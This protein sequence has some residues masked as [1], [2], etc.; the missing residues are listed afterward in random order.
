MAKPYRMLHDAIGVAVQTGVPLAVRR[1]CTPHEVATWVAIRFLM[2]TTNRTA[3]GL[4]EIAEEMNTK[5]YPRVRIWVDRLVAATML[6]IIG[7][8]PL[9][10]LADPR[11]IYR[12]PWRTIIEQS[13]IEAE[14]C[15][16]GTTK[17]R[18]AQIALGRDIQQ[19]ALD[20][21]VIDRSQ[22][23]V[24]DRS[25]APVIDRSQEP[26]FPV[27]DRS[28]EMAF[29]VIDRSQ[30]GRKEGRKEGRKIARARESSLSS[31]DFV[32]EPSFASIPTPANEWA[33]PSHPVALWNEFAE[34]QRPGDAMLLSALAAE[35]DAPTGGFG[36]YWL[37]R[38]IL[39]ASLAEN[40]RSIA[41]PRAVLARWRE[42]ASYGSDLPQRQ[43]GGHATEVISRPVARGARPVPTSHA[44]R[45]GAGQAPERIAPIPADLDQ[46]L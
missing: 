11:P 2:E 10:N 29:P 7:H 13:V 26:D 6:E 8:E 36:L 4:R 27:I 5:A 46:P 19:L 33:L 21:P 42:E 22:E 38:A 39:T 9:P 3:F 12:I 44:L 35:H 1:R 45:P 37:G 32:P 43:R 41:K 23:P 34:R 17:K 15:V 40:M 28:Q 16:A 25:Q 24:I 20:F 14:K 30:H 18:L 31:A